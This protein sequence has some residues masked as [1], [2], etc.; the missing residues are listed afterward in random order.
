M[1]KIYKV[2]LRRGNGW[3]VKKNAEQIDGKEFC[4]IDGWRIEEGIYYGEIA[5]IPNDNKY[6]HDAPTLIASGDLNEKTL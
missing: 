1:K 2:N 6:P 5:M 3:I 4:F